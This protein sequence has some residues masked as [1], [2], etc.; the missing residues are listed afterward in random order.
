MLI[1]N[2]CFE[3][4]PRVLSAELVWG[5][6]GILGERPVQVGDEL[7]LVVTFNSARHVST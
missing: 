4:S 3:A 6:G 1:I 5:R 7:M 2:P